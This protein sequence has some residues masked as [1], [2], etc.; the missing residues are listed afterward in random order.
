MGLAKIGFLGNLLYSLF[1]DQS[2]LLKKGLGLCWEYLWMRYFRTRH[3][4]CQAG[5]VEQAGGVKMSQVG[6]MA[7]YPSTA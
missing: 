4:V 2:F 1:T 6:T 5:V 3:A 7:V